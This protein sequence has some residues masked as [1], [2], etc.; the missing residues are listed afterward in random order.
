MKALRIDVGRPDAD[1]MISQIIRFM[2]EY[3]T[4]T[5][6]LKSFK[7]LEFTPLYKWGLYSVKNRYWAKKVFNEENKDMARFLQA[8]HLKVKGGMKVFN[9]SIDLEEEVKKLVKGM[10][11]SA[12]HLCY[13]KRVQIAEFGDDEEDEDLI[14]DLK[15]LWQVSVHIINRKYEELHAKR[16]KY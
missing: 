5:D 3:P 9:E 13:V 7:V 12:I 2:D 14:N 8:L 6:D 16:K 15:N 4:C 1:Y 11:S 10:V